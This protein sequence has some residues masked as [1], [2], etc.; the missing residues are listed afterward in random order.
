MRLPVLLTPANHTQS[1]VNKLINGSLLWPPLRIS[2]PRP[3]CASEA[4]FNVTCSIN[5]RFTYLLSYYDLFLVFFFIVWDHHE[6]SWPITTE[7]LPHNRK[8]AYLWKLD[9][10]ICRP[11]A[12]KTSKIPCNF[13]LR[14]QT[15]VKWNK[16]SEKGK[17]HLKLQ[18][19]PRV[20]RFGEFWSTNDKKMDQNLDTPHRAAITLC[21]APMF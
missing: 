19:I 9:P 3:L 1:A 13:R 18:S 8:R 14:Q 10:K 7:L 17:L 5:S 11:S 16:I 6:V 15:T 20:T 4:N 2:K 12:A 21:S